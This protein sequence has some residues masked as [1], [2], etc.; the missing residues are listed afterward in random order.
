MIQ[1]KKICGTI[2]CCNPFHYTQATQK[3]ES[4]LPGPPPE[5]PQLTPID[6]YLEMVSYYSDKFSS[7][8]F[9]ILR[10]EIPSEDIS[11]ELLTLAIEKLK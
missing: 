7:K 3:G 6:S 10:S 8:D 2:G 1:G 11:D 5:A 4:L 9:N